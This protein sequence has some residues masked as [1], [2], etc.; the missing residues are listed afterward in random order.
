M[1]QPYNSENSYIKM[2]KN[3]ISLRLRII[4]IIILFQKRQNQHLQHRRNLSLL[5]SCRKNRNVLQ[6]THTQ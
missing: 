6:E 1:T 5:K 3:L 4:K 2:D